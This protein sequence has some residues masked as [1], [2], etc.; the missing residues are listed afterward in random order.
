MTLA[1]TTLRAAARAVSVDVVTAEVVTALTKAGIRSVLLKGPAIARL[2]YEPGEL[3][4][5][6]DL[7]LLVAPENELGAGIVLED[8]GFEI[9]VD[10]S[11]L[12]GHRPL[13]A[14]EWVRARDRASVDLHRTLSG[15]NAEPAEVFAALVQEPETL[16]LAG[17]EV[18]V[19]PPPA[20]AL[21]LA[22][23]LAHHGWLPK[24]ARDLTR[25]IERLPDAAWEQAA[26]LARRLGAEAAFAAGLEL[27]PG[28]AALVERLSLSSS[29]PV[30]VIL[31]ATGPPPL[32]LGLEWLSRT[33]GLRAKA[34]LVARTA[35]PA[36]G[37]LRSWRPL[38]RR[39]RLGLVAAYAS[40]PFWLVR[41]AGPSLLA[42]RRAR[43]EVRMR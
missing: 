13:H 8:L 24:T 6:N 33:P 14:H 20:L 37:A 43:R 35:L 22:L 42:L 23:H 2:L 28:G 21:V 41:H 32:A 7:D 9:V 39:G 26:Q 10:D 31:R 25:A 38:A 11:R 30:D 17:A 12:A 40:H 3:R 36:R 5:Y 29:R 4:A 16:R 1:E 15:T 18:E 19:P 27:V 34:A